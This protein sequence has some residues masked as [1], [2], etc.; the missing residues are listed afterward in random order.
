MKY[1]IGNLLALVFCVGILIWPIWSMLPLH[2]VFKVLL[3]FLAL[4][5]AAFFV[6]RIASRWVNKLLA[7]KSEKGDSTR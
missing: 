3:S 6:E 1:Q 5:I 7:G 2:W 4:I